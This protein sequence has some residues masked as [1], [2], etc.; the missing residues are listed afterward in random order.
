MFPALPFARDRLREE[1]LVEVCRGDATVLAVGGT[2]RV[3][4]AADDG[5]AG[6]A[7]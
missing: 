6:P 1:E 3:A 7:G 2:L 4:A 5:A